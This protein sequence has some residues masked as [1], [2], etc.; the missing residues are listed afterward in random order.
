MSN[1]W[2]HPELKRGE[3]FIGNF[4]V[5][6]FKLCNWKTKRTG[7]QAYD[8]EHRPTCDDRFPVF[9]QRSEIEATGIEMDGHYNVNLD[10]YIVPDYFARIEMDGS[11]T[12]E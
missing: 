4:D 6:S 3:V 2:C 1:E 12:G 8:E 5:S 10:R 7:E 9:I 11:I